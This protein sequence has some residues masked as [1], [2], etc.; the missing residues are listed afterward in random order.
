[1]I[2]WIGL[3]LVALPAIV[4]ILVMISAVIS[5][6]ITALGGLLGISMAFGLLLWA[7]ADELEEK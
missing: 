2:K 5:G 3:A 6:S 4:I 1:M 7:Y